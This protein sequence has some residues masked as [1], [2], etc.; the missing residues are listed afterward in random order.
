[1]NTQKTRT[2]SELLHALH[3]LNE[4]EIQEIDKTF[5]DAPAQVLGRLRMIL[6]EAIEAQT[7]MMQERFL[8]DPE[9]SAKLSQQLKS[10][11][12]TIRAA[13]EQREQT[14]AESILPS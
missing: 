6:E 8:K 4:E 3:F 1:M 13:E 9:F 14:S 10:T 11:F 12:Q 2:I 7:G 5:A